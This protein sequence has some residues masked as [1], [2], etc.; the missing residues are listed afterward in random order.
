MLHAV[1][2]ALLVAIA[3]DRSPES[4]YQEAWYREIAESRVQE[5]LEIYEGLAARRELPEPLRAK[6]LFRSG[7]CLR[8]LQ[9]KEAA[10]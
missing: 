8:K 5:A 4:L 3:Q 1:L 10:K 9:R 2:T 6:A 7:V